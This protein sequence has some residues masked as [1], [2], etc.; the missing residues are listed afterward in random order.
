MLIERKVYKETV[1]SSQ[2]KLNILN[3][4]IVKAN[5]LNDDKSK[6]IGVQTIQINDLNMM[7]VNCD[8]NIALMKKEISNQKRKKFVSTV[9]WVGATMAIT[10][11]V[12]SLL[13]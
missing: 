4:E 7:N 3:S 12:V 10:A 1:V 2:I 8:Q 11:T 9:K 5:R 13:K 6:L